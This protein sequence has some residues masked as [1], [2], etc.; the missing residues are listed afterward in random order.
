MCLLEEA[1]GTLILIMSTNAVC[2]IDCDTNKICNSI[3]FKA[4]P[5]DIAVFDNMVIVSGIVC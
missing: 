3:E 5:T 4:S 1:E 2:L